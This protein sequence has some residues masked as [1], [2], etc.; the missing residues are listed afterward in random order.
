MKRLNIIKSILNVILL[1]LI[2]VASIVFTVLYVNTFNCGFL[3][4]N[5]NVILVLV[6]AAVCVLVIVA[7]ICSFLSNKFI[8]KLTIITLGIFAILISA[9]YILKI[10][11]VLDKIDSVESLRNYVASFGYLAVIIY[12]LINVLQVVLLPIPGFILAGTGVALFGALKTA[13]YSFFGVFLGS[14]IAF[15]IGRRLGYKV[16]S[17]LVGKEQLDKGIKSIKRKDKVILTF[18]FLF[19]LFPDDLLCFVAGL[20]SMST[21]YFIIMIFCCRLISAFATAFSINGSIIPYNTWWGILIWIVFF[22]LVCLL[23]TYVYKNGEVLEKKFK[24]LFK[25]QKQK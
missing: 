1:F 23:A 21:L 8:Y 19:P 10:T 17:W 22:A 2:G 12:V 24:R 20:S 6:T 16:V 25:K 18:M 9:L 7:L 11:G 4:S 13:I 15:F 14:L 3:V 5:K